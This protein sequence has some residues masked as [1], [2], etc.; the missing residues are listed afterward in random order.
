MLLHLS[1]QQRTN[2]KSIEANFL[3]QFWI[4]LNSCV[5]VCYATT[6]I[7]LDCFDLA[8][9]CDLVVH[10]DFIIVVKFHFHFIIQFDIRL[11]LY[12]IIIYNECVFIFLLF[13]LSLSIIFQQAT[14]N[15]WRNQFKTEESSK[16]M[17]RYL[18]IVTWTLL[19]TCL[20]S[21]D[22]SIKIVLFSDYKSRMT[23]AEKKNESFDDRIKSQ[24][25]TKKK[26]AIR[27]EN[28]K[29]LTQHSAYICCSIWFLKKRER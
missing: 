1:Q 12:Y 6:S 8:S 11:M 21:P 4:V 10:A 19:C 27:D 5:Y 17:N 15:N 9:T 20:A 18:L 7:W 22:V 2:S 13:L 16:M 23:R 29:M 14:Y 26:N 24:N 25:P 3:E 28:L